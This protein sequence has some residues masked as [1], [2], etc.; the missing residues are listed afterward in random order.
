MNG[1]DFNEV[2]F[3]DDIKL[4]RTVECAEQIVNSSCGDTL[5][6]PHSPA[7]ERIPVGH[8]VDA[9]PGAFIIVGVH[10]HDR[11]HE[12]EEGGYEYALL[13]HFA[14]H[15]ERPGDCAVVRDACYHLIV[16][17]T[18]QVESRLGDKKAVARPAISVTDHLDQHHAMPISLPNENLVQQLPKPQLGLHP[19]G[20]LSHRQAE[21]GVG[22]QE[23]MFSAGSLQEEAIFVSTGDFVRVQSSSAGSMVCADA[24]VKV[25]KDINLSAF[26]TDARRACKST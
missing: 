8:V 15:C 18:F 16:G 25:T 12:T 3:V 5:R 26:G 11:E 19:S 9:S 22:Q 6:G 10:Q 4:C 24:G 21:E 2:M 23:A 1:L 7:V 14:G 17:L 20:F 13:L